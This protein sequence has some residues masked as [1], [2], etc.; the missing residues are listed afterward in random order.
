MSTFKS[1]NQQLFSQKRHYANLVLYVQAFT[2]ILLITITLISTGGRF[3]KGRTELF[4]L[5]YASS[6][7]DNWFLPFGLAIATTVIADLVFA[8]LMTWQDEKID[9][10]QTFQLIPF[11]TNGVW[12]TNIFSSLLACA[13]L[14]LIQLFACWLLY[15]PP[16]L[17]IYHQNIFSDTWKAI[18][19]GHQ[20][21]WDNLQLLAYIIVSAL[22]V[23]VAATFVN[24]SSKIISEQLPFNNTRWLR[25]LII[26]IIVFIGIYFAIAINDRVNNYYMLKTAVYKKNEVDE[27]SPL[28]LYLLETGITDL[29]LIALNLFLGHKYWEPRRDH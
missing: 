25:T 21:F 2:I 14:F 23:L 27:E 5:F 17:R 28:W 8:G 15:I 18:G 19:I 10:S 9:N 29:I 11:S 13:Y 4:G 12:L 24:Y 22:L 6:A 1:L 16:E 26:A 20:D 3:P 7:N